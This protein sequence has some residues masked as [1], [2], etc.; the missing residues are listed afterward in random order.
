MQGSIMDSMSDAVENA[1]VVLFGV[2]RLY[3][4]R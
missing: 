2:S 4:E 3:K 1:E